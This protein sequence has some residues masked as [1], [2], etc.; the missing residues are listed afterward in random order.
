[1]YL[2]QM[3]LF[4]E[5]NPYSGQID[6]NNRWIQLADLVPWD[7]METLYL[8]YFDPSKLKKV[9]RCRLMMGLMIGQIVLRLSDIQIVEHFHENPYFQYFCG[10]D[11]FVAKGATSIIDTSLLSKRRTRLGSQFIQDFEC[12]IIQSFQDKG[13]IKGK[14][15]TLDAT[16]FPANISYP[17][18]IKLL[19]I[20]RDYCCNAILKVKNAINPDLKVRTYRKRAQ[21]IARQFQKTKKKTTL[22]IRRTRK[23]MLQYL[24]RNITQLEQLLVELGNRASSTK[25]SLKDWVIQEIKA[26][27]DI[28]KRIY[29]Q[30]FEM[31]RTKGRRV[32]N[33]IVSFKQPQIRPIIRGKEG[34]NVEFGAKA[35][36]AIVDGYAMLDDCEFDPYHEGNL[37]P[38]SLEKHNNRFKCNPSLVLADQLYATRSNRNL[39]KSEGIEQSFRPIGRPP[40]IS[41]KEQK[42]RRSQFKKRQGKRNHIEGLFGTLKSHYYLDRIRWTVSG[43]ANMQIRMGLIASNLNRA[44]VYG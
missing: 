16:V 21:K 29:E 35:H 22:Y 34:K 42:K 4:K 44:L 23:Q 9:K 30:Q 8:G 38:K 41:K 15:L 17:S 25:N 37:L 11:T 6:S 19:N 39:L 1:M 12:K 20:A 5:L 18:D 28:A 14:T 36:V 33:R 3:P 32:S 13:L 27:L 40:N 7:E 31:A 43:G 2:N 24:R 10:N 26:H